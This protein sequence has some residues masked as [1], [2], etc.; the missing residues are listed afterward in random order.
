[1]IVGGKEY[2]LKSLR[3][4]NSLIILKLN[5]NSSFFDI[6]INK[7]ITTQKTINNNN[8]NYN[9][10]K[11]YN[12][13]YWN[14]NNFSF[15]LTGEKD[16]SYNIIKYL[17]SNKTIEKINQNN[18]KIKTTAPLLITIIK[19]NLKTYTS[20]KE[21]IFQITD[22]DSQIDENSIM[23]TGIS[24]FN[25]IDCT[26]INNKIN[27]SFIGNLKSGINQINIYS[28]DIFKN[29]VNNNYKI[30]FDN[31]P[32][33][34]TPIY[35]TENSYINLANIHFLLADEHSGLNKKNI[36][37]NG[38]NINIESCKI[39]PK[40]IKCEL[41]NLKM[42]E[43]KHTIKIS[44]YDNTNNYNQIELNFFYD[45][46][47]PN[48]EITE[49]GFIVSDNLKLKNDSLFLDNKRYSFDNCKYIYSKYH[50]EY[51]KWIN[52]FSVM[53]SA[54]NIFYLENKKTR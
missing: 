33:N 38:I 2:K 10:Y 41:D 48:I 52:K 23:V 5:S 22:N 16:E 53:D 44:G 24:G 54:G 30:L 50:C 36:S 12:T 35:P 45:N 11:I 40:E 27:C 6:G 34:F 42:S 51:S 20:D 7:D 21:I 47:R 31:T 17:L 13:Y 32:W 28:K 39:N 3:H 9:D 49:R 1:N 46:L 8:I 37:I 26:N 19:P 4:E 15:I 43:G 29:Q 25:K 18:K 14:K